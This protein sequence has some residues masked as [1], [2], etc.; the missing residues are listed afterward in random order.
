MKAARELKK[1]RTVPTF[2]GAHAIPKEAKN[3]KDYLES[4][5]R[6]LLEIKREGLAQRVDIFIE[7]G[8]FNSSEAK[9]YLSFARD[10]GFQIA[11]H[12]DQLSE[13][14]GTQL[15]LE[16]RALSADHVIC[17]GPMSKKKLAQSETTAVLLPSADF[18]LQ[19]EYPDARK[20]IEHGARI[21]L[22]TDFNPG[23]SP[24]QNIQFVG[25]LARLKMKMSLPE[26]FSA[27]TVGG[28][29][30]LGRQHECGALDKG[31]FAD[32]FVSKRPWQQF[33]YNL[34]LDS[35]DETYVGGRRMH[36]S[37]ASFN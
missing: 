5:Q 22:A 4:L 36:R 34:S 26:V 7:K 8:Y 3:A 18:F 19:C 29:Y 37:N 24:T 12:A 16:L 17:L 35:V 10:L 6:T 14:G 20:L 13:S 32:F 15:A 31:Y 2:L 21:A 25:L 30:A 1:A 23:S 11:I 28:A 9:A 27:F 33:F